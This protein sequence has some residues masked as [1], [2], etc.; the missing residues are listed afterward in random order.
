MP[1][2]WARVANTR[3]G[4]EAIQIG[5]CF[6]EQAPT[7]SCASPAATSAPVGGASRLYF[8]R[9]ANTTQPQTHPSGP[10]RTDPDYRN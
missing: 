1:A 5:D 6:K 8:E 4:I 10:Y 3:C 9:C 2:N 7:R